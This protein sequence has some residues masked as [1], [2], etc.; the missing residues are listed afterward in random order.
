MTHLP[1]FTLGLI[2]G[3]TEDIPPKRAPTGHNLLQKNRRSLRLKKT[4]RIGIIKSS[5]KKGLTNLVR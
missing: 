5:M 1:E 2:N 4:A 3:F